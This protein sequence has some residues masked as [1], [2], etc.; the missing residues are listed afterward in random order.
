MKATVRI[1]TGLTRDVL[2]QHH[3][4]PQ[5]G[6]ATT[7]D[8][9]WRREGLVPL[10]ASS[11][12]L[13]LEQVHKL[14]WIFPEREMSSC[15]SPPE[16]GPVPKGGPAHLAHQLLWLPYKH[17]AWQHP[18]EALDMAQECVC[19]PLL[20][21]K[22]WKMNFSRRTN[23]PNSALKKELLP[24]TPSRQNCTITSSHMNI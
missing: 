15:T 23:S 1:P 16:E 3:P 11:A 6:P 21:I 24:R 8:S 12:F 5:H 19:S 13:Q 9:L 10:R 20:R 17:P 18:G 14:F 7:G 22:I 4:P 2:L